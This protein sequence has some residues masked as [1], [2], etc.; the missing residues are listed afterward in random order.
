MSRQNIYDE[1]SFYNGYRRLRDNPASANLLVEK[2]ALFSLLPPLEGKAVLDL[3]CGFGENCAEF[4]RQGAANVLGI[5]ISPRGH[6]REDRRNWRNR[7]REDVQERGQLR[8]D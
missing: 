1:Q 7:R 2:P 8:G 3:G 5:D 6:F 4:A